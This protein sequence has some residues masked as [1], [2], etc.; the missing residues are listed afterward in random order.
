MSAGAFLT[1]L[2]NGYMGA[3]AMDQRRKETDALTQLAAHQPMPRGVMDASGAPSVGSAGGGGGGSDPAFDPASIS[4]DIATGILE[5]AQALE[6]D[7]IDLATAISYETGGTFN[8]VQKGPTTKW[9]QHQGF[10]QFGEPQAKEYGVDWNNPVASQLGPDGA[11]VRYLRKRGVKPG[12]GMMDIYSTINA[13]APGLYNR[14]DAAAGGAPGTVADKV[15]SQ[16]GGH[17]AKA[18]RLLGHYAK[19]AA[20]LGRGPVPKGIAD[21]IDIGAAVVDRFYKKKDS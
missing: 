21:A 8:P 1:G 15:T 20:S 17:R 9:G 14:S 4:P 3:S 7:P 11:V 5:S 19:P 16:M 6:V 2:T 13:G 18:E 10:I 12:M